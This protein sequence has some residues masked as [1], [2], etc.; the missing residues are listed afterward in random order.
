MDKY[1]SKIGGDVTTRIWCP[2]KSGCTGSCKESCSK[3]CGGGCIGGCAGKCKDNQILVGYYHYYGITDNYKSMSRFRNRV[4]QLLFFWFNR[5]SQ[6]KSYTWDCF[7]EF[8]RGY[9]IA[10]PRIYVSIY[11]CN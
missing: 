5:R 10:K 9:P 11:G 7:N 8:L 6:R 4:I 3:K 2:C 1:S